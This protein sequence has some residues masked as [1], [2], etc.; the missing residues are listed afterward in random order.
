MLFIN[1]S[2]AEESKEKKMEAQNYRH[3]ISTGGTK[4]LIGYPI[5]HSEGMNEA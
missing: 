4:F 3:K 1:L 2:L 5:S